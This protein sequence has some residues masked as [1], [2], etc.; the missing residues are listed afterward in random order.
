M[1][2]DTRELAFL[3]KIDLRDFLGL[4]DIYTPSGRKASLE[5]NVG[6]RAYVVELHEEP[7]YHLQRR[8]ITYRRLSIAPL[9]GDS[10]GLIQVCFNQFGVLT[11]ML[12]C[13]GE[14]AL[15][16]ENV[17]RVVTDIPLETRT[18]IIQEAYTLSQRLLH[19]LNSE[20]NS[21]INQ[22]TNQPGQFLRRRQAEGL[23]PV[24]S[25]AANFGFQRYM[26]SEFCEGWTKFR[27]PLSHSDRT[28][29]GQAFL[30]NE[31]MTGCPKARTSP[32][33]FC[34]LY[35]CDSFGVVPADQFEQR[36]A[37]LLKHLKESLGLKNKFLASRFDDAEFFWGN[38]DI[39]AVPPE[40]L[41]K[42]FEVHER[43][44]GA[45]RASGRNIGRGVSAFGHSRS[46]RR[47]EK[48][49]SGYKSLGLDSVWIG[50]ESGDDQCLTLMN[51]GA[52]RG[53]HLAAAEL[54]RK[55]GI[56]TQAIIIPEPIDARLQREHFTNTLS[57]LCEVKP[58]CTYLSSL[59]VQPRTE[60]WRRMHSGA[61]VSVEPEIRP[62]L[63]DQLKVLLQTNQLSVWAYDVVS[64]GQNPFCNEH[65]STQ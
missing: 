41:L 56:E 58:A 51:K 39:F 60:L 29:S 61:L 49:L 4:S 54:L 28:L 37:R 14:S 30:Y 10:E 33:I 5:V 43:Y 9:D 63:S 57:L 16:E 21:F 47:H 8:K 23:I 64:S 20:V 15:G 18:R 1:A 11:S 46:I 31:V 24:L 55:A 50:M 35:G 65:S 13:F 44:F 6:G 7:R 38:G 17:V 25:K 34:D 12:S 2:L 62:R 27:P 3:D 42:R 22:A 48:N 36:E 40:E 32:C 53:D 45:Y 52:S 26:E 59:I 19:Q